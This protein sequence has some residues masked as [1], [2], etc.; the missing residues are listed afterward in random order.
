M[1]AS[2]LIS[3][4]SGF[5]L[6]SAQDINLFKWYKAVLIFVPLIIIGM[7]SYFSG[8]MIKQT[9][10]LKKR[11]KNMVQKPLDYIPVV[12]IVVACGILF[13][14]SGTVPV[15]GVGVATQFLPPLICASIMTG[16]KLR[17]NNSYEWKEVVAAV[18]LFLANAVILF[19]VSYL[20]NKIVLYKLKKQYSKFK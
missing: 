18:L 14:W 20:V 12:I 13:S 7:I 15:V 3:P 1:L 10:E 19:V 8:D 17:G 2:M 9:E 11:G 6:R 4:I 5:L 16:Q